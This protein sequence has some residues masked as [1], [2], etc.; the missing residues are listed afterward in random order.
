VKLF[1]FQ[2][3]PEYFTFCQIRQFANVGRCENPLNVPVTCSLYDGL[4]SGLGFPK[5]GQ[6]SR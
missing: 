2:A 1:F 6:L 3:E 5:A 4:P